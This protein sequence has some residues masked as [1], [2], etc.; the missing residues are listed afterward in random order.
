MAMIKIGTAGTSGLGYPNGLAHCKE[1]GLDALEV[2]FTHGVHMK[3]ETAN[4][5]GEIAKQNKIGLSVH[6]PYFINLASDEKPK[7]TASKKRILDSCERAHHLGAKYVVFHAGFYGKKERE[8]VYSIISNE[9]A[10]LL[11]TIKKKKLN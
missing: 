10:D 3:N 6:A 8:D 4:E 5:V 7:V 2:E 1:L 9:I 11:E